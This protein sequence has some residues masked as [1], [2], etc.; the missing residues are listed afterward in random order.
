MTSKEDRND[1]T[2]TPPAG[3]PRWQGLAGLS[4]EQREELVVTIAPA[5][6]GHLAGCLRS[7]TQ[8]WTSGQSLDEHDSERARWSLELGR[9]PIAQDFDTAIRDDLRDTRYPPAYE[10]SG[11]GFAADDS[12]LKVLDD[13]QTA[14]RSLRHGLEAL[15]RG[16][17]AYSHLILYQAAREGDRFEH[18]NWAPWSPLHWFERLFEAAERHLGRS[19][20]ALELMDAYVQCLARSG[21][22]LLTTVAE[23]VDACGLVTDPAPTL[24]PDTD[25]VPAASWNDYRQPGS[26]SAQPSGTG[27]ESARAAPSHGWAGPMPD[28]REDP[29]AWA[30][31]ARVL[32]HGAGSGGTA[33]IPAV[34]AHGDMGMT[35]DPPV[36]AAG[37]ATGAGP[38]TRDS[39]Q[40]LIRELLDA[41]LRQ[42]LRQIGF[43]PGAEE[44]V[45]AIL[46][47]LSTV[48]AR[49]LDFFRERRHPLRIWL[50]QV[51]NAGARITPDS[52]DDTGGAV[53]RQLERLHRFA[54]RLRSGADAMDRV[55]A[56]ALLADWSWETV[57][58]LARWQEMHED[59]IRPLRHEEHVARACRGVTVC[60]L[61]TGATLPEDAARQIADAWG[62]ILDLL[63][64]GEQRL[65]LDL[66]AV[67]RA[68]CRMAS[69]TEVNALV[70]QAL[71]DAQRLGIPDA[72]I[73]SV[74]AR[75]G[76]AHLQ[77]LRPPPDAAAFDPQQSLRRRRSVRLRDDDPDLLPDFDDIHVFEAN[78]IRAGDWCE[79]VDRTNGRLQRMALAWR[80]EA[81]RSFLFI[82]LDGGSERRHSLQGVANELREGRMRMLPH[83]NP[84]DVILR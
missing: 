74:F 20:A 67:V 43:H 6:V 29:D 57:R 76:Q 9:F 42:I 5:V 37:S 79:F 27:R 61:E 17:H 83:D 15:I 59:R 54:D 46:P 22:G 3:K 58:D 52:P 8:R 75:L 1:P 10:F 64:D 4:P 14:R 55:Q 73:R 45:L 28:A 16:E 60:V 24:E 23:A 51:V 65:D 25:A 63:P 77:H 36:A 62:E 11:I 26:G 71:A 18:P 82:P 78:R 33:G 84:I 66:R 53:E 49:D 69:P 32:L 40:V 39:L 81:T 68:I 19:R 56:Q 13:Y 12:G 38:V 7:T 47:P 35:G 41:I 21:S 70:R 80:G 2:A 72:R 48:V 34:Q 50:G 44:G 30:R 31:W